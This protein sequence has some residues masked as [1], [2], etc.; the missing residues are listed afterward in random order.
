MLEQYTTEQLQAE[1][2]KRGEVK[3]ARPNIRLEFDIDTMKQMCIDYL[4]EVEKGE[5]A[6]SDL[7]HYI[8]GENVWDWINQRLKG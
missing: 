6:D 3:P 4:D 7:P 2:D 8:F 1:I 5:T